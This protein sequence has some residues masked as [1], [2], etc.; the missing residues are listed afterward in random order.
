MKNIRIN[1]FCA[2]GLM[3]LGIAVGTVQA[4]SVTAKSDVITSAQSITA[5]TIREEREKHVGKLMSQYAQVESILLQ[6]LY[7]SCSRDISDN[8]YCSPLHAAILAVDAW[9]ISQADAALIEVID[10]TLDPAS[11]PVGISVSGDFF[12]PAIRPLVRLRVDIRKVIEAIAQADNEKRATLL[13]WVLTERLGSDL[14]KAAEH[15]KAEIEKREEQK[16]KKNLSQAIER[17]GQAKHSPDLIPFPSSKEVD[18]MHSLNHIKQT[19]KL[20]GICEVTIN[21]AA[22]TVTLV[23][24]KYTGNGWGLTMYDSENKHVSQVT[25]KVNQHC[26]L[27]DGHHAFMKYVIKS[28]KD[29][30]V[31]IAVT[32]RFDA[33]S[34]GK[35]VTEKT[36]TISVKPYKDMDSAGAK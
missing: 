23:D 19:G 9:R 26:R 36:E 1:L 15:L 4:D 17:I 6:N 5:A 29:G 21:D 28:I 14:D 32:E 7:N 34:F 8:T 35:G 10:Y 11:L 18:N 2:L 16:E 33:R 20:W 24:A 13:S 3:S 12:Y 31:E 30:I 25:L 22:E 27:S